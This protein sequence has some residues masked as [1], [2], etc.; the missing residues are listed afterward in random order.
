MTNVT[1]FGKVSNPLTIIAIF[2]GISE[3]SGTVVLPLIEKENQFYFMWFVIFFPLVLILMFFITLW[4][5]HMVLYAPSDFQS[6]LGF[7]TASSKFQN[8]TISNVQP[9]NNGHPSSSIIL[10]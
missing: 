10:E 5:N 6:D 9:E 2:A 1:K 7:H 4:T 8:N 3:I